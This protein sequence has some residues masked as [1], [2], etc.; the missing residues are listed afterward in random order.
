MTQDA[1]SVAQITLAAIDIPAMVQFYNATFGADLQPV[2]AFDTTLYRGSL[3]NVTFVICPNE[4]AGVQAQQSRHQFSYAVLDLMA[5]VE[6]AVG[7][8]GVVFEE[9]QAGDSPASVTILDPDG[10]SMVF[11]QAAG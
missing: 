8:G 2:P 4:L 6:R 3:H 10:N 7:A 1:F 11:V 9:D 5:T